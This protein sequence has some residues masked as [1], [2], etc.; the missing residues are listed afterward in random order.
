MEKISLPVR[1]FAVVI[2]LVGVAGML[3]MRTM[4]PGVE[5]TAPIPV[6]VKKS[7][8]PAKVTPKPAKAAA[9]PK[10]AAKAAKPKPAVN[11]VVPPSGFPVVVDRALQKHEV[12]VIALVVPGARVDEL[13]AA[14]AEAGAKLS[15]AGFLALNVLNEGVAR[16][17]LAKLDSVQDPSVLVV[18]RSGDVAVELA[19]FADRETVAQ[20]AANAFQ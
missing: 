12:V 4:G 13:A 2:V 8:T 15:G 14:E 3:A 11:P 7:A 9:A 20:A 16:A 18:K 5:E 10:T 1:I 6:P 17:L 19:G